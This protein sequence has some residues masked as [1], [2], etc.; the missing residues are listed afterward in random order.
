MLIGCVLHTRFSSFVDVTMMSQKNNFS[1]KRNSLA[2]DFAERKKFA[3]LPRQDV[4][5]TTAWTQTKD[6]KERKL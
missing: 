3:K 6:V 1:L 4:I 2:S 5:S